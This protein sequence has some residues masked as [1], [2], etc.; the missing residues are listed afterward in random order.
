MY[1]LP[2]KNWPSEEDTPDTGST[3]IMEP[4]G[5]TNEGL[6]ETAVVFLPFTFAYISGLST[7]YFRG[8]VMKKPT[9][10]A[11]VVV[12]VPNIMSWHTTPVT[13]LH[14]EGTIILGTAMY[15]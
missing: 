4:P 5:R 13:K 1:T 7:G 9:T 2:E 14:V 8:F 3:H 6:H 11:C 10:V 15:R 12:F